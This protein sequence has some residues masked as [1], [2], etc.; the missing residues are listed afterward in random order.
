MRQPRWLIIF[1]LRLECIKRSQRFQHQPETDEDR[2]LLAWGVSTL[3]Q[4]PSLDSEA[5]WP[6]NIEIPPLFNFQPPTVD[7]ESSEGNFC[8]DETSQD[9]LESCGFMVPESVKSPVAKIF[10]T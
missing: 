3:Q 5:N 4:L 1:D 2:G 9:S 8:S 7:S 6:E 10:S